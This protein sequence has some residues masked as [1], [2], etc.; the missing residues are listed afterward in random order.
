[1]AGFLIALEKISI[2]HQID[3][4]QQKNLMQIKS[5]VI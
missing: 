3:Q 2:P 5:F 4:Q 1:M